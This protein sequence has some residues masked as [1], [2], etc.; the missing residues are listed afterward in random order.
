MAE[1]KRSAMSTVGTLFTIYIAV[2][3]I[4]M[5]FALATSGK[6]KRAK[7]FIAWAPGDE[8]SFVIMLLVAAVWP[9]WLIAMLV[10]EDSNE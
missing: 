4:C 3:L 8:F 9:I 10:K 6:E 5:I 2:G 1:L 7:R